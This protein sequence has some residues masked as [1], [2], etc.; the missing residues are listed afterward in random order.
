M[1]DKIKDNHSF[2]KLKKSLDEVDRLKAFTGVFGFDNSKLNEVFTN[3]EILETK[4]DIIRNLPDKFN[5]YF[6]EKGWIA[7][8]SMEDKL[9]RDSVELSEKGDIDNAEQYLVEFYTTESNLL[10]FLRKSKKYPA[11]RI[12][13]KYFKYAIND[14]VEQRYYSAIPLLLMMID[15][16]VND[17]NNNKGFFNSSSDL[18]AW[19]SIAGHSTGLN[20]LKNII[21]KSRAR[22]NTSIITL[23]YRNGI[24]H[25]RDLGYDNVMVAA[26]CWAT[27]FAIK[28]WMEAFTNQKNRILEPTLE[29]TPIEQLLDLYKQI[30]DNEN[31]KA[32]I[33]FENENWK[34][35][36]LIIGENI[37]EKGEIDSYD[38]NTPEQEVVRFIKNWKTGNYGNLYKQLDLNSSKVNIREIK[39][40]FIGKKVIDYR[41]TKIVD[42]TISKSEIDIEFRIEFNDMCYKKQFHFTLLYQDENRRPLSPTNINGKWIFFEN[43][44]YD[45]YY[46]F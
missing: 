30:Q 37:L 40:G 17:I 28:D 45:I 18:S 8:E 4:L 14:T 31:K 23:P 3:N 42:K 39:D 5:D 20:V 41:F 38:N 9:L 27:L 46:L 32:I 43:F 26:K 21:Y 2:T 19:D 24:L 1:N 33:D 22:T 12:R 35:R 7:H 34:P 13:Y 10:S 15:G 36:S 44:L 11:F 6:S 16:A 25:G 29:K